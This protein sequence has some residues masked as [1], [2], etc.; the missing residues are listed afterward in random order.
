MLF[1]PSSP[2]AEVDP[3]NDLIPINSRFHRPQ[4]EPDLYVYPKPHEPASPEGVKEKN[5]KPT[6]NKNKIP[7]V[8]PRRTGTRS[9]AQN[10]GF[11]HLLLHPHDP[12]KLFI[13]TQYT[14][15]ME[16]QVRDLRYTAFGG[17]SSSRTFRCCS[18]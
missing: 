2:D 14:K 18:F 13:H 16:L 8:E 11:I 4:V 5:M 15:D 9:W 17:V 10:I 1:K 12:R 3:T 7:P 6:E